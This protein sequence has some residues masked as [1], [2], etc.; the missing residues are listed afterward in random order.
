MMALFNFKHGVI[1]DLHDLQALVR[2]EYLDNQSLRMQAISADIDQ[3]LA[4]EMEYEEP[5]E[6]DEF[7]QFVRTFCAESVFT[8][9]LIYTSIESGQFNKAM[10]Y[11]D[12]ESRYHEDCYSLIKLTTEVI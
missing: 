7:D 3:A 6:G 9:I 8:W 11:L 12:N 5:I 10:G 2:S 4:D 1:R